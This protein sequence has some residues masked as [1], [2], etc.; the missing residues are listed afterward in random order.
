MSF[1]RGIRI[2]EKGI[3]GELGE[4]GGAIGGVTAAGVGTVGLATISG[5]GIGGAWGIR[6]N[7]VGVSSTTLTVPGSAFLTSCWSWVKNGKLAPMMACKAIDP[8][9]AIEVGSI[10]M[11]KKFLRGAD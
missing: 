3:V 9:I 8:R 11:S 10:N 5:A 4:I 6:C 7:S 2:G 1:S